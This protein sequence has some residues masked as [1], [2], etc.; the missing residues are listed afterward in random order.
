[1]KT[2]K[3]QITKSDIENSK[4]AHPHDCAMTRA[5][6]RAG[7]SANEEG[8]V[9]THTDRSKGWIATPQELQD[10]VLGMYHYITPFRVISNVI[11]IEPQDFEFELQVPDVWVN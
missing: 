9:F 2:I 1:M 5:I 10:K 7:I 8:G 3:I 11:A 4:Y 6:R